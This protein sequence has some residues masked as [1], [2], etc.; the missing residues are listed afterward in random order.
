MPA[1]RP[2]SSVLASVGCAFPLSIDAGLSLIPT[3]VT[4]ADT[5][6]MPWKNGG[7]TTR[8]IARW[9]AANSGGDLAR[10]SFAW[11]VSIADIAASCSF[12]RF[13]DYDRTLVMLRGSRMAL[14][15]GQ[16]PAI[17]LVRYAWCE[18][19][20]EASVRCT[21]PNGPV[22]DLNV[23]VARGRARAII[24]ILRPGVATR[25]HPIQGSSLLLHGRDGAVTAALDDGRAFDLE[26]G[27]TLRIDDNVAP[28]GSFRIAAADAT[29][30][31]V[32][33][34]HVTPLAA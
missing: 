12:S 11:R 32:I 9:P 1:T 16:Q 23:M 27:D 31:A 4:F 7:G 15:I 22:Q 17:D 25:R 30:P 2:Q 21:L 20:G 5:I 34:I 8:E 18:F 24:E 3:L 6:V 28:Y 13:D 33:A 29:S 14:H 26:D 19:E 10:P